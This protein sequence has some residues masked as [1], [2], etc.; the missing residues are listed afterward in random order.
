MRSLG[1]KITHSYLLFK[2]LRQAAPGPVVNRHLVIYFYGLRH[3]EGGSNI[4]R[5]RLVYFKWNSKSVKWL[6][7][8]SFHL[9]Q[10]PSSNVV[11]V[12][13]MMALPRLHIMSSVELAFR[14][15]GEKIGKSVSCQQLRIFLPHLSPTPRV[16]IRK[17]TFCNNFFVRTK[18]CFNFLCI[19]ALPTSSEMLTRGEVKENGQFWEM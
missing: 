5:C 2:R 6:K 17:K 4:A 14:R 16:D 1:R 7:Q 8:P 19:Y 11:D 10:A 3:L 13:N 15:M 18:S 12:L 9:G